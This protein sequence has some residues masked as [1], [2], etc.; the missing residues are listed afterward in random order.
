[1]CPSPPDNP[2]AKRRAR[3][4]ARKAIAGVPPAA[5]DRFSGTIRR[6]LEDWEGFQNART[7][8]VFSALTDEP[9][10]RPLVDSAPK[11]YVFPRVTGDDLALHEVRNLEELIPSRWNLLEPDPLR[12]PLVATHEIELALVP[13]VAFTRAGL[14]LGRGRGFYD[15]LLGSVGFRAVKCGVCFSTQV[16]SELPAAAHD[17]GMDRVATEEGVWP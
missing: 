8:L 6:A 14:R 17:A 9:D 3:H 2:Q 4:A 5:R 12:C 7:V 1:M 16:F 10:L 13:G 15:R 11:R